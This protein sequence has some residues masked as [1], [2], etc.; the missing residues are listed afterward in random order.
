[1]IAPRPGWQNLRNASKGGQTHL[2][3]AC[4][5]TRTILRHVIFTS[6]NLRCSAASPFLPTLAFRRINH[7]NA[8]VYWIKA[9]MAPGTRWPKEK[10]DV[11]H[12]FSKT[13]NHIFPGTRPGL[14]HSL[15]KFHFTPQALYP[16]STELNLE[17]LYQ[18]CVTTCPVICLYLSVVSLDFRLLTLRQNI[19]AIEIFQ[20]FVLPLQ[21]LLQ[22]CLFGFSQ[23]P[24]RVFSICL[25]YIF[26]AY[27]SL[28]QVW[29]VMGASLV[30]SPPLQQAPQYPD[31]R[32]LPPQKVTSSAMITYR[33]LFQSII[34]T[35]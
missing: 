34:S 4:F 5:R 26:T 35:A 14:S 13:M 27:Y 18:A 7:G 11:D 9:T 28:Q 25:R 19:R 1:M 33:P 3:T 6:D 21:L 22:S 20:S 30:Q 16:S 17:C 15:T 29:T 31:A 2:L 23:K 10:N 12:G 8:S 24:D 32:P